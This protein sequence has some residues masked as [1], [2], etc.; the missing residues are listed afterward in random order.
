[1]KRAYLL[2][3]ALILSAVQVAFSFSRG[4]FLFVYIAKGVPYAIINDQK[5]VSEAERAL[6]SSQL[7]GSLSKD[8]YIIKLDTT[9][10]DPMTDIS[11]LLFAYFESPRRWVEIKGS[12]EAMIHTIGF[13]Q[14]DK[15]LVQ[16]VTADGSGQQHEIEVDKVLYSAH[17]NASTLLL[18]C[19]PVTF[20]KDFNH[21]CRPV[22]FLKGSESFAADC[23]YVAY[24]AE[25]KTGPWPEWIPKC[26][27]GLKVPA[28]VLREVERLSAEL[29][30]PFPDYG[31]SL[32]TLQPFRYFHDGLE[33]AYYAVVVCKGEK[34]YANSAWIL[35]D[36][37]RQFKHI[38]DPPSLPG[39]TAVLGITDANR[40]GTHEVVF[41]WGN[42]YGGGVQVIYLA[43]D[44]N[45]KLELRVGPSMDTEFD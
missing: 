32:A 27:F 36:Q 7:N 5:E 26:T 31:D 28:A 23:P 33:Q 35:D 43:L 25:N 29:P 21:M 4:S 20:Q 10:S 14:G 40:D 16:A 8:R 11:S 44:R 45:D 6:L 24:S 12:G 41:M 3:V 38:D 18:K 19:K 34:G 15:L 42:S 9:Y 13:T 1:M 37:G 17:E 30:Q 39:Y 2:F 22:N